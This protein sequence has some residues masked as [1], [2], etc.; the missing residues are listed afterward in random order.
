MPDEPGQHGRCREEGHAVVDRCQFDDFG[1]IEALAGRNDLMRRLGD[2]RQRVEPAAMRQWRAM[3]H[4]I[5]FSEIV[6][7]GIIAKHH[8]GERPMCQRGALGLSGGAAGVEQPGGVLGLDRLQI[9]RIAREQQLV[10][11]L[12]DANYPIERRDFIDQRRKRLGEIRCR[13]ADPRTGIFQNIGELPRVQLRVDRHG[14]E[15]RVPGGIHDLQILRAILHRQTDAI[16]RLDPRQRTK[17]RGETGHAIEEARIIDVEVGADGNGG[18]F[19]KCARGGDKKAGDVH[20]VSYP[21]PRMVMQA[22]ASS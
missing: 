8:R 9:E 3:Q 14:T 2:V 6:D 7:V 11:G 18:S 19:R 21:R 22:A 17:A 13:K 16:A 10:L 12:F 4:A 5:G 15:P 1:G 20:G